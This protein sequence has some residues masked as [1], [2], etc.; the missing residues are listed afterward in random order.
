[1]ELP[2]LRRLQALLEFADWMK[3]GRNFLAG[4]GEM[5]ER[6]R[7]NDWAA[8]PLGPVRTWPQSLR[9]AV[10]ICLGSRF[11]IVIYWGADLAV[12]YNDAYA[13]ILGKKHPWALGRP[14]R[15]SRRDRKSTRLNSSHRL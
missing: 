3:N 9:S 4:G 8:T 13:E 11:P 6:M 7:A 12:L 5:G 1:V 14:C 2:T 15:G 10:S